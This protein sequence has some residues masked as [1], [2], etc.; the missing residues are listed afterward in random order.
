MMRV[1]LRTMSTLALVSFLSGVALGQGTTS[2][3]SGSV[4]D[5]AGAVIKG[6]QVVAKN[7]ASGVE[8]KAVTA[9]NGTFSI[10]ALDSGTYSV[11]VSASGFKVAVLSDVKLDAGT[12]GSVRIP[13]EVGS[14]SESVIVQGAGEIVQTQ[15]ANI[16]TT[17]S[18]NASRTTSRSLPR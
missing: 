14:T 16:A 13:L 4:H 18:V 15:S 9:D 6:A 17:L 12:T 8:F 2:I 3:L 11:T 10:P 7:L 5:E 1:L